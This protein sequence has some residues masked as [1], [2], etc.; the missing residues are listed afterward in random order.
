M[1]KYYIV[2]HIWHTGEPYWS[3]H[4][5]GLFARLGYFPFINEIMDTVTFY[6]ADVCEKKLKDS[7]SKPKS[8]K[9]IRIIKI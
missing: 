4:K 8:T 2:Q 6:N 1:K 7:L 3:A 9:I 5:D